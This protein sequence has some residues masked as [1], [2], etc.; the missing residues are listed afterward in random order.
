MK[1]H[2]T[3]TQRWLRIA[4]AAALTVVLSFQA[5]FPMTAAAAAIPIAHRELVLQAGATD[6]GSKPGGTVTHQFNFDLTDTTD[7]LGSIKFQYCTTAAAVPSGI[8]CDAPAGLSTQNANL[9]SQTGDVTAFS[10]IAQGSQDD[11][12]D[13]AYNTIVIS[14]GAAATITDANSDGKISANFG[15]TQVVNPSTT[16]KTF[17]VRITTYTSLDAS[18]TPLESG[19]VAAST[20]TPIELS[21]TMPESLVFCTGATISLTA[22]VPDCSTATSGVIGFDRLFSPTDTAL[23]TSQMAAST[24]AGSGYSI[25]VNGPTLTSGSNS[26]VAMNTTDVSKLG[27]S[28]FGMNVVNNTGDTNGDGVVDASDDPTDPVVGADI[29]PVSNGT[30]YNAEA[31]TGYNTDSQ[32]TFPSGGTAVVADST[33]TGTDSQI[34]TAS[35]IVNVPGSQ[36]AGGYSTTLTYIC[37]ATF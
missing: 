36:P 23:A 35:Y 25:T 3:T 12:A 26:I 8:D 6:G 22:G 11:A 19:T 10:G 20:A 31:A 18:G 24:N 27:V 29:A 4:S 13:G 21:G 5:V 37:T 9:S 34:Y 32:Y 1:I 2:Q 15:F 28:Q 17:F 7:S 33:N 16:N 30:N 14:R